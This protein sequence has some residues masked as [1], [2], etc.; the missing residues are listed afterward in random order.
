MN[1]CVLVKYVPDTEAIVRIRSDSELEIENKYFTNFFDEI[2]IEEAVK[3]KE[4]FGGTVTVVTVDNRRI[5]ALRR[6]IAMGADH[7]VQISDAALEGSDSFGIARV[8]AAFLKKEPWDV[9][10]CGRQAMDDDAAIVGPAVAE[11]LDL[12]H[13]S[14]ILGLEIAEDGRSARVA[15]QVEGGREILLCPLP[16]VLTTQKGLNTPR[17]PQVMGMMKAMKVQVRKLDLGALGVDPAEVGE[18]G[19]KVRILRY[20][21]PPKR[22]KAMRIEEDFPDNVRRLVRLLREEAKAL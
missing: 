6:G 7:A 2:A 10:L 22:S 18:R 5:D 20:L 17:I 12:P 1:I 19:R 9:I 14:S 11:L 4:K 8:L 3:L 16:A 21:P 15:R 13:V